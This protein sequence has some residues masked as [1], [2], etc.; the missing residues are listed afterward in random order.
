ML[1]FIIN[2]IDLDISWGF[3]IDLY[4]EF[5]KIVFIVLEYNEFIDLTFDLT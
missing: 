1:K 3:R 5:K 2:R 4:N